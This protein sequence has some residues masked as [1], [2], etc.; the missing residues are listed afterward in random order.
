MV[1][2]SHRVTNAPREWSF[3]RCKN[4]KRE[5]R[6][7]F[8]RQRR[9]DHLRIGGQAEGEEPDHRQYQPGCNGRAFPVHGAPSFRLACPRGT[10]VGPGDGAT[11]T[12]AGAV[13]SSRL[14]PPSDTRAPRT[15]IIPP[16]QIQG[17]SG[18][19]MARSVALEPSCAKACRLRYKSPAGRLRTA[20]VGTGWSEVG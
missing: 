15:T 18:S 5:L 9:V 17:T 14:P 20:G 3:T 19:W 12:F 16:V 13:A 6:R 8:S 10:G 11:R 7:R 4:G 2:K 1:R